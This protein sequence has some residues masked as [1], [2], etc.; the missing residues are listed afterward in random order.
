MYWFI[1]G[2][3]GSSWLRGL[4]SRC[5]CW[6]LLFVAVL[7]PLIAGVSRHVGFHTRSMR[8]PERRLGS[9]GIGACCSTACATFLDQ[10]SN[11]CFL[12][13]QVDSLPLRLQGSPLRSFMRF[14]GESF[15]NRSFRCKVLLVKLFLRYMFEWNIY[16]DNSL[17][18]HCW[19]VKTIAAAAAKSRQSC[20][21]LCDPIDGSP[22]GSP[23]PGILQARALEWVAI[24]FSNTRLLHPWEFPGKSTGEGSHCLLQKQLQEN[25]KMRFCPLPGKETCALWY[26]KTRCWLPL[27]KRGWE[28]GWVTALEN[29]NL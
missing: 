10:E 24:S 21:T 9:R 22:P 20:P 19:R 16:I 27:S 2:C 15:Y 25:Q 13:W 1:F 6:E 12:H 29:K 26:M 8:A 5:G 3:S 7:R 18:N 17:K 28:E 14:K 11:L 23:V 4:F